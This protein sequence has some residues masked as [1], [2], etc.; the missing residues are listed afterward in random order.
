MQPGGSGGLPGDLSLAG[1]C[2]SMAVKSTPCLLAL[3]EVGCSWRGW[4]GQGK[5]QEKGFLAGKEKI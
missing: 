5:L 4:V 1:D 3:K 2:G